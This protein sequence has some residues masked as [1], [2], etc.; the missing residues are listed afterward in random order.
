VVARAP[1][2]APLEPE[3]NWRRYT[4]IFGVALVVLGLAAGGGFYLWQQQQR[5]P[6]TPEAALP[7]AKEILGLTGDVTVV[8]GSAALSPD[9]RFFA[10]TLRHGSEPHLAFSVVNLSEART[11][12]RVDLPDEEPENENKRQARELSLRTTPQFSPN[13]SY[14]ALSVGVVELTSGDFFPFA[15]PGGFGFH[16]STWKSES[17]LT[18]AFRR[19]TDEADC[20]VDFSTRKGSCQEFSEGRPH[21]R[22]DLPPAPMAPELW[23]EEFYKSRVA[24]RESAAV[25][26][27]RTIITS[28]VTFRATYGTY[29][30]AMAQLGPEGDRLIDQELAS[31]A[32]GGYSFLYQA[33]DGGGGS[34]SGFNLWA[35]PREGE[36]TRSFCANESGVIRF[37]QGSA[38]NPAWS[39]ALNGGGSDARPP[40]NYTPPAADYSQRVREWLSWAEAS[41][42]QGDYCNALASCNEVLSLDPNN[43]EALALRQ[44]VQKTMNILGTQ[45]N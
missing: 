14:V 12:F 44:K 40:S 32:K 19:G 5:R 34:G 6:A 22:R 8:E 15:H 26:S 39:A 1:F 38:C 4:L 16:R 41:F 3:T 25:G 27:L 29:P 2:T 21:R 18:F 37:S 17:E 23:V 10:A 13:L 20:V 9:G 33:T 31:G 42:Q 24:Q 35:N 28:L 43:K 7:Q 45:C 36:K 11:I 30:I